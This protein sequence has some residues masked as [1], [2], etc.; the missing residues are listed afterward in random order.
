MSFYH[1]DHCRAVSDFIDHSSNLE[2]KL[3]QQDQLG[4]RV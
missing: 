2:V 4:L 3:V 1:V